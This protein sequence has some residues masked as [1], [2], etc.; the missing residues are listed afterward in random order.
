MFD[1]AFVIHSLHLHLGLLKKPAF[2]TIQLFFATIHES[3]CTFCY[4]S[5]ASL[6]YF[7]YLLVLSTVLSAK[8]F[9]FHLNKMFPKRHFACDLSSVFTYFYHSSNKLRN[10]TVLMMDHVTCCPPFH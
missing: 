8:S 1:D 4:N 5:W 7:S 10:Y 3:H 2:F 6:Y 9:Q